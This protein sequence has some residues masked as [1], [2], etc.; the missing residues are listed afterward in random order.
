MP[1]VVGLLAFL[2]CELSEAV[3]RDLGIPVPVNLQDVPALLV[4]KE[5]PHHV[6]AVEAERQTLEELLRG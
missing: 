5:T 3:V 1:V 2:R 6:V 4:Y